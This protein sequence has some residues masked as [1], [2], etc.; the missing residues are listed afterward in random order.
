M[1]ENALVFALGALAAGLLALVLFPAFTRRAARLARR[2]YE[3]SLPRSLT[4]I[5]A[6]RDGVKAAYAARIARVEYEL[7]EARRALTEERTARTGDKSLLDR[8]L[9]EAAAKTNA[10]AEAE[11]RTEAL[12][13]ELRAR[14]EAL[15]RIGAERREMERL[16]QTEAEARRAAEQRAEE[17]ASIATDLRLALAAA[18][19]RG[20]V[21]EGAPETLRLGDGTSLRLVTSGASGAAAIDLT[22]IPAI[23]PPTRDDALAFGMPDPGAPKGLAAKDANPA[24]T[25]SPAAVITK[26]ETDP[27]AE[28]PAERA[29]RVEDLARRL[30]A[31]KRRNT[32]ARGRG[33]DAKK[34]EPSTGGGSA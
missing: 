2:D 16:L 21:Y 26:V 20:G 11:A 24:P 30:K 33:A 12:R 29:R 8:A 7:A 14:D 28:D 17:A 6:A 25:G 27:I 18:E 23:L 4:E 3:A 13:T 9:I 5:A 15:A 19:A 32:A 10:Y 22:G 1:I 31:L 34:A